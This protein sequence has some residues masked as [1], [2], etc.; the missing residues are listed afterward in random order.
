MQFLTPQTHVTKSVSNS[1]LPLLKLWLIIE[2][3]FESEITCGQSFK[4]KSIIDFEVP[5][6]FDAIFKGDVFC[7]YP[8]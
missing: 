7:K 4:F 6:W 2:K 8:P 1:G 3:A 5:K